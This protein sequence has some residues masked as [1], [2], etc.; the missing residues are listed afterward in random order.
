MARR[1]LVTLLTDF[2]TADPYVAAMKGVILSACPAATIVD[3][4][5]DIPPQDVMAAAF[6]LVQAALRFPPDTLH[7]VVVDPGVGT[8]RG[9]LVGQFDQQL[10]LFPD[11][12]VITFV[13]NTVPTK[14]LV[15]VRNAA[16]LPVGPVSTTFHGRDIF[17]PLAGKILNGLDIAKLGPQPATYKTLELP[18]VLKQQGRITGQV[19]YV[20]RFGNLISNIT[21]QAVQRRWTD[22]S[23]LVV[24]CAGRGI[25]PLCSTYAHTVEGEALALFN[26]MGLVEVA[27]NRG[28][29]RR[30]LGAAV[31]SEVIVM[32]G[33]GSGG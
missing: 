1:S 31:G 24:S 19:I 8:G 10:F 6:V 27:V 5:H 32:E 14:T 21:A 20:D 17:A 4:T 30:L 13:A 29:A 3:I 33:R 23:R 9:I 7:V 25:G 15:I 18:E 26:S 12:G 2:G 22:V 28:S 11:N 16:Y